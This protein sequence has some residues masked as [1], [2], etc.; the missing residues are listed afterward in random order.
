LNVNKELYE[1]GA[2]DGIRSR[3]QQIWYITIPS[4]KPQMLFSAV[5]AIVTTFKSGTI[6]AQ[7][8]GQ[9]PTPQYAG[10]VL[11]SHIEDYGAIRFEMGY[12]AAVSVFLL[13]MMF[14]ANRLGIRLFGSK[15]DE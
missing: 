9:N 12:A 11:M 1:A 8:S 4:M 14:I 2:I 6:G 13:V 3:L 15:G 5:M 7:L 10:H